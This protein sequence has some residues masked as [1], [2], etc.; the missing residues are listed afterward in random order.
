MSIVYSSMDD[1]KTSYEFYWRCLL[2]FVS[3]ECFNLVTS[4]W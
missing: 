3:R 2:C 4:T 1:A